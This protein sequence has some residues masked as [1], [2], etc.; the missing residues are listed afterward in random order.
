[1]MGLSSL[2]LAFTAHAAVLCAAE[3][4]S[5]PAI[6]FDIDGVLKQN[7]RYCA[8]ARYAMALVRKHNIPFCFFTNGGAGLSEAQYIAKLRK[9]L[10]RADL[11]DCFHGSGFKGVSG[12]VA[13]FEF[14][15]DQIVLAYSPF[16]ASRPAAD[17]RA[18]A[19]KNEAVLV[20]G[21]AETID[22]ARS[23]GYT[24][25]IHVNEYG[26]RHHEL[27]P[28]GFDSF[29][30]ACAADPNCE[31]GS[32]STE[33]EP[34]RGIL[35]MS[36][37]NHL[38]QALQIM[39]DVLMSSQPGVT[40]LE[41]SSVAPKIFFANM[42]LL[43]RAEFP[44]MRFATG[45]WW[46]ALEALYDARLK[47]MGL[48]AEQIADRKQGTWLKFGKPEASQYQFTQRVLEQLA[49]EGGQQVSRFYMVGDNH[50]TDIR[51]ATAMAAKGAP[52]SSVLV[53]TGVW[54]EGQ[55][56]EG[57]ST[58]QDQVAHAVHWILEQHGLGEYG[59][60][61]STVEVAAEL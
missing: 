38:M 20:V 56:D 28:I 57:A 7:T 59:G 18:A 5:T 60:G 16:N 37:P 12:D 51:G 27:N 39:V 10:S 44:T 11:E 54:Q 33:W 45:A 52:W 15:D 34:V 47:A 36:E 19:L 13:P 9:E 32:S 30:A 29:N 22:V 46:V 61:S 43:W 2:A 35:A 21:P 58:V 48:S 26:R 55:F 50:N 23:Y 14:T 8:E 1:M 31:L 3:L 6:A 24:K 53:R 17:P 41:P 49:A 42:D 40:E 4:P 25:A